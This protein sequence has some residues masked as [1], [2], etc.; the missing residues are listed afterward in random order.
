MLKLTV[1]LG[2]GGNHFTAGLAEWDGETSELIAHRV[3]GQHLERSLDFPN[4]TENVMSP[5]L[6]AILSFASVALQPQPQRGQL[7]HIREGA[8]YKWKTETTKGSN[9]DIRATWGYQKLSLNI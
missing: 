9:G 2:R 8:A 7:G 3:S 4:L 6:S 1:L 5:G